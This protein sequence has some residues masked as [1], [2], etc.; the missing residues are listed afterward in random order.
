MAIKLT[1]QL[2]GVAIL[3]GI[4][5]DSEEEV[6]GEWLRLY[7]WGITD[8]ELDLVHNQLGVCWTTES[9]WIRGNAALNH[10]KAIDNSNLKGYKKN[11]MAFALRN[12]LMAKA[13]LAGLPQ[14]NLIVVQNSGIDPTPYKT[15]V[16]E[17]LVYG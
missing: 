5:G 9:K 13:Q 8:N 14:K 1:K 10:C 2:N 4:H 17:G 6:R 16:E 7:N 3:L 12:R 15:G 11:P